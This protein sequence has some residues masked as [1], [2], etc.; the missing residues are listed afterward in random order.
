MK[1]EEMHS[2]QTWKRNLSAYNIF[3]SLNMQPVMCLTA[4]E[5][6]IFQLG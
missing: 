6:Q 5:S 3:I 1:Q 4:T 2:Y